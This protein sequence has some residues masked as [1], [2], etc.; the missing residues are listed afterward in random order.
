MTVARLI[1][2]RQGV[3]NGIG[4]QAKFM[5][6]T[7]ETLP[8]SRNPEKYENINKWIRGVSAYW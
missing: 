7:R 1:R 2:T 8:K 4:S 3:S 5:A 6:K